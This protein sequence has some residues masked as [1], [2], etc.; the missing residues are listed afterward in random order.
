MSEEEKQSMMRDMMPK[1]MKNMMG[2]G[3]RGM[4]GI[5]MGHKHGNSDDNSEFNPFDMC[6]EMMASV[7][8]GHK[9]ATLATPE[10]QNLFEDWV[11]QIEEEIIALQD[12]DEN[13]TVEHLAE[14]FKISK[15]SVY[16]F[17]TRLAQKGKLK[18]NVVPS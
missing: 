8:Q 15:E 11:I 10:I 1:M 9:T 18:I 6:K 12:K 4:M 5:M 13:F 16:Y 14:H 2:G 7:K 17:L 3:M